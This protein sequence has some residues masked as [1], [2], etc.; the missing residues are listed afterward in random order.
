MYELMCSFMFDNFIINLDLAVTNISLDGT[1]SQLQR[2][3]MPDPIWLL[4]G[5]PDTNCAATWYSLYHWR[6]T[7]SDLL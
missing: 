1:H 3:L 6:V 7:N 2:P 4:A 5:L